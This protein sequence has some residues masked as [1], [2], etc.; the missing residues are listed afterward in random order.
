M[1]HPASASRSVGGENALPG[2]A[3]GD[4]KEEVLVIAVAVVVVDTDG[5]ADDDGASLGWS[6]RGHEESHD[7]LASEWVLE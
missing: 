3:A 2:L 1:V 4:E 5:V 7:L 6:C